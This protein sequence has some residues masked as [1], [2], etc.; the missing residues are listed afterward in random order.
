MNYPS[1]S[2]LS[3]WLTLAAILVAALVVFVVAAVVTLLWW[4]FWLPP[5][6]IAWARQG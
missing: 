2:T 1:S 4:V 6:G 3:I 5:R